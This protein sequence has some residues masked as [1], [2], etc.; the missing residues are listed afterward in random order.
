ME[1]IQIKVTKNCKFLPIR[2]ANDKM[3]GT[4]QCG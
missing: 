1:Q 4:I 3:T 2:L